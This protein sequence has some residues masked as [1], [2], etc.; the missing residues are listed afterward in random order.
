[1]IFFNS[2]HK[3]INLFQ[4]L[5]GK[6]VVF[7]AK[8]RILHKLTKANKLKRPISHTLNAVHSA[9]INMQTRT[10]MVEPQ[11]TRF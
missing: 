3:T 6:D 1:M 5:S 2:W 7:I 9:I 8:R 11:R 10:R 4:E